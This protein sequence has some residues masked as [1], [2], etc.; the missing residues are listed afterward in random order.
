MGLKVEKAHTCKRV[1]R[2]ARLM[3]TA[4]QRLHHHKTL[5]VLTTAEYRAARELV[6]AAV[7]FVNEYLAQHPRAKK[8]PRVFVWHDGRYWLEYSTLGRVSVRV[9]GCKARFSSGVFAI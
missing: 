3:Q 1:C 6:C 8:M 9:K 2:H 5:L 7:E 4:A